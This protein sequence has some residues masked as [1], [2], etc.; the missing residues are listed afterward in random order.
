MTGCVP[1]YFLKNWKD[2]LR[3]GGDGTTIETLKK[4]T[5]TGRPCGDDLFVKY[6]EGLLGRKLGSGKRGKPCR[7]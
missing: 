2:Y 1:I 5:K 4:N 3:E 7:K 6:V